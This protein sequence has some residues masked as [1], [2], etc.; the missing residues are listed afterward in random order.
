MAKHTRVQSLNVLMVSKGPRCSYPVV[1]WPFLAAMKVG[2]DFS[3]P[4]SGTLSISLADE[5]DSNA[6]FFVGSIWQDRYHLEWSTP[7][8]CRK[9]EP[10]ELMMNLKL[11]RLLKRPNEERQPHLR[12]GLHCTEK[13]SSEVKI[14]ES[15]DQ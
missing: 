15:F 3:N 6:T 1:S 12:F 13:S 7:Q 10:D 4:S 11:N 5:F 2:S 8:T 9:E 14:R